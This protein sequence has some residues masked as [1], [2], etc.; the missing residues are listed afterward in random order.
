MA[1]SE[2]VDKQTRINEVEAA[3]SGE[4]EREDQNWRKSSAVSHLG[5]SF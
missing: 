1:L 5:A 3:Y 4:A 2:R